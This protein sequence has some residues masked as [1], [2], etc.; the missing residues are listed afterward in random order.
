MV[1][2]GEF[3]TQ[4]TPFRNLKTSHYSLVKDVHPTQKNRWAQNLHYQ[5]NKLRAV[6]DAKFI[7]CAIWKRINKLN[8]G[9]VRNDLIWN[10]VLII[11]SFYIYH[12]NK[13]F[14][15]KA[16]YSWICLLFVFANR[17]LSNT[18][19]A[20]VLI[21]DAEHKYLEFVFPTVDYDNQHTAMASFY[22]AWAS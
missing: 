6:I 8:T 15:S 22:Q 17:L 9:L 14:S 2:W 4:N 12:W 1:L 16:G 21:H 19:H 18:I 20:C 10:L 5:G 3:N 7:L 11:V 13:P